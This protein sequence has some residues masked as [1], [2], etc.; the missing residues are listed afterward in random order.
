MLSGGIP[1]TQ[2]AQY[3]RKA[4]RVNSLGEN[5]SQLIFRSNKG[6]LYC[7]ILN[8]FLDEVS[9]D[10]D[11]FSP[12]VLYWILRYADGCIVITEEL[13]L[14]Y[15]TRLPSTKVKQPAV[16]L[17]STGLLAQSASVYPCT[18]RSLF[19]LNIIPCPTVPLRSSVG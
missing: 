9:V 5:I 18:P 1:E 7:S 13:T 14:F 3:T 11:M 17:L 12:I 19:F 16:D 2:L 10:F 6:Q 15:M 4:S 8:V